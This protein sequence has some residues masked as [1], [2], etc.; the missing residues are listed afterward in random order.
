MMGLSET[1]SWD[2]QPKPNERECRLCSASISPEDYIVVDYSLMADHSVLRFQY[3]G[4]HIG[5][6]VS[7]KPLHGMR[8]FSDNT[9]SALEKI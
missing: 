7:N 4:F 5:I 9:D 3:D 2:I 1:S 6:K 8:V